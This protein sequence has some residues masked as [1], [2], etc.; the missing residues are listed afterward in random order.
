MKLPLLYITQKW[1]I[2]P[3]IIQEKKAFWMILAYTINR[4]E[5]LPSGSSCDFSK[6]YN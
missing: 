3:Q 5:T 1:T 4:S 2:F 6:G